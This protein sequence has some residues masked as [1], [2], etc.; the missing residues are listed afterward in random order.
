MNDAATAW[1][2]P[3]RLAEWLGHGVD[4]DLVGR[5]M[6][7][8]RL[9]A[10]CGVLINRRL[11]DVVQASAAQNLALSLDGLGVAGLV[12]QAGAVW[13]GRAIIRVIDGV[14]VRS[15]VSEI[16]PGLRMLAI[17][18][19]ALAPPEAGPRTG[20]TLA[21]FIAHDGLCCVIAWCLAQPGAV[22][23]LLLLRL[24]H[25]AEPD[26]KHR[27]SGPPILDA[28]LASGP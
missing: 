1:A 11:G 4:V 25:V 27:T 10:R 3:Q 24:P 17:R 21:A 7:V 23:R 15:L 12:Q 13:H 20:E 5:M 16:G 6:L 18:H 2:H 14:E 19:A 9:Q 8:P 28:L 26:A 22:G